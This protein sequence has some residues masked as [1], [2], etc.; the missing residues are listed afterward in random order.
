MEEDTT[1]DGAKLY[2]VISIIALY[3]LALFWSVDSSFRWI[4][5]GAASA[6]GLIYLLKSSAFD[7]R[8][9]DFF[10]QSQSAKRFDASGAKPLTTSERG[11]LYLGIGTLVALALA[12]IIYAVS[13]GFE[14]ENTLEEEQALEVDTEAISFDTKNPDEVLEN[15]NSF[16]NNSQFD[17]AMVYY[18]RALALR[19]GFKEAYY[20]IALIY[21]NQSDY[22]NA[23]LTLK[24]CLNKHPDYGDALQ[25]MGN[26]YSRLEQ[27][28]EAL[29]FYERSYAT[30]TRNAE[31]SHYMA[32]LYDLKNNT[33]RAVEFYKEALQQDSS[34]VEVYKRLAE[35][36]PDKAEWYSKKSNAWDVNK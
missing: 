30:G 7:F 8:L 14:S 15:G 11:A 19:P 25:L 35:L 23:I 16:Y 31:L 33:V 21:S 20:N 36:E 28:D 17:S 13:T 1:K 10:Q 34:K 4:F 5:F 26:C 24:E 12:F 29:S 27:N 3:S 32:Y 22:S 9:P 2:G 18:Q 6:F